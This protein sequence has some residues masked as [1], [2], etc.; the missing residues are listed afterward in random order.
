MVD[1][2]ITASQ[3][4]PGTDGATF[5]QGTAGGTITAGQPVYI[6]TGDSNKVK[7]ADAN[8]ATPAFTVAGIALHAALAGQPI[9]YQT[10][11]PITLGA[12]A[13]MTVGGVYVL[14]ATAGGI[15]PVADLATG[16][17]ASVLGVATTA[18]IL[19]LKIHN[20]GAVRP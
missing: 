9:R 19:A 3:V 12:G 17:Y 15:A 4:L 13:A 11:G 8:A 7:A 5:E 1:I 6:D 2:A 18:A 16:M 10:S 14:S 20:S